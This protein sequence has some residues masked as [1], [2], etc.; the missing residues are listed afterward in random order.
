MIAIID[1][2]VGNIASVEHAIRHIGHECT[3]TSDPKIVEI[4][5]R[6][7]I[8]G[9]GHFR[10]TIGLSHRG[11][12]AAI[13]KHIAA[14]KPLF[15]ICL[16]MQWL[17]QSSDEAPNVLGLG[18]LLGNCRCFST[19]KSLHVGWNQIDCHAESR[20]LRGVFNGAFVY[21]TH[22]YHAPVVPETVAT[23]SYGQ[24]FSAVVERANLFGTQFHPEKSGDVGLAILENF[25]LC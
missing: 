17:F 16:G 13:E 4:A 21:F 2:G 10:S 7:I 5:D 23:A 11:M 9:V 22:K 3:I 12:R 8:P 24:P 15:G 19:A 25:C 6:V 1:Y 18:A 20:L 14:G